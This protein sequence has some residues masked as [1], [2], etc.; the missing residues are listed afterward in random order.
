[1]LWVSWE[2]RQ[3]GISVRYITFRSKRWCSDHARTH[4]YT[5]VFLRSDVAPDSRVGGVCP[6]AMQNEIPSHA[7]TPYLGVGLVPNK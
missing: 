1:M 2:Q 7:N 4:P 5:C 6:F 3:V